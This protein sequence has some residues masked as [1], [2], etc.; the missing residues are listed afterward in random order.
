M[1]LLPPEVGVPGSARRALSQLALAGGVLLFPRLAS[2][3]DAVRL[4]Y[5]APV[6]CPESTDFIERVKQRVPTAHVASP[7]ELARELVIVVGEDEDGFTARLDFVD[8]HGETITRTLSGKTC[9]EVVTGI[10]LVT[11]LALEAQRETARAPG[12]DAA[13]ATPVPGESPENAPPADEKPA[14]PAATRSHVAETRRPPPSP[15][16][17]KT[18]RARP[19]PS[20]LRHGAGIGGGN[21]WF[22]APGTPLVFDAVFRLG[23]TSLSGSARA[24]FRSWLSNASVGSHSASFIGY[25]GALEGCPLAWPHQSA[26][27]LE[28]CLGLTL[29]VLEAVGNRT[30]ELPS[31]ESAR[32]FWADARGIARVRVAVSELVELEAQG[33]LGVPLRTHRFLFQNPEQTVFEVPPYGLGWRAGVMLHFP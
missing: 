32:I 3:D 8:V 24:G 16:R 23:H 7:D 21:A 2:A 17:A 13:Q 27:R 28:P 4:D 14:E 31:V 26:L 5:L 18:P 22:V 10:A 1:R 29:G 12:E 19:V 11:A 20:A 33:E 30:V 9:D 25:A 15:P 6:G